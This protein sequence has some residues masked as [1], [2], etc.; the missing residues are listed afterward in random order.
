MQMWNLPPTHWRNS[1]PTVWCGVGLNSD[2]KMSSITSLTRL[3]DTIRETKVMSE[4][5]PTG[6][7]YR[8]SPDGATSQAD[9]LQYRSWY[10]RTVQTSA[11]VETRIKYTIPITQ[12]SNRLLFGPQ[13]LRGHIF[14]HPMTIRYR[15]CQPEEPA[16]NAQEKLWTTSTT[17]QR[18]NTSKVKF[19]PF[20]SSA[21][22][23]RLR[24]FTT[25]GS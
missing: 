23:W 3:Q 12:A 8:C 10:H 5:S 9:E 16:M 11:L 1:P 6:P 15:K 21:F 14:C 20:Y 22:Y 7:L 2:F 13:E 25:A 24:T 17:R 19:H 18:S 4:L